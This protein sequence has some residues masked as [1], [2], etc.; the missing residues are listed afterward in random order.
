MKTRKLSKL[1]NLAI[2]AHQEGTT[3]N[4][5]WCQHSKQVE[6]AEPWDRAA[7]HKLV[8]RLLAL[9]TSGDTDGMV[10]VPNGWNEPMPWEL[11]DMAG[12][13]G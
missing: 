6:Q 7:Y 12:Q 2:K 3:W 11:D 10:P 5:F 8:N 1:E 13:V 9:L 4:T